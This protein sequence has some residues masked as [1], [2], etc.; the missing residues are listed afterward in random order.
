[1]AGA[2]LL[3]GLATLGQHVFDL[4]FHIDELFFRDITDVPG[5]IPGRMSPYSAV[6]FVGIGLALTALSTRRHCVPLVWAAAALAAF[7]GAVPIAGYLS[8]ASAVI[9]NRWLSPVAATIAFVLLGVGTIIAS[10]G[11]TDR[12]HPPVARSS[13]EKKVIAAFAGALLLLFVGAGFTYRASVDF[14]ESVQGIARSEQLRDALATLNVALA[15][16]ESAQTAYLV[17]SRQQQRDEYERLAASAKTYQQ[18]I[19]AHAAA[20]PSQAGDLAELNSYVKRRLEL[21]ARSDQPLR[22]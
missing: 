2:V 17:T 6:A 8:N 16:A 21:L 5:S 7:I 20:D 22:R 12:A 3:L 15:G 18:A 9:A 13:V 19:A 14:T 11:A 10:A 4:D 1:M